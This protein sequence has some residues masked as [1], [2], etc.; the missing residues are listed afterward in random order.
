[1]KSRSGVESLLLPPSAAPSLPE[2][3]GHPYEWGMDD[4]HWTTELRA[5]G[6]SEGAPYIQTLPSKRDGRWAEGLHT[7]RLGA[8]VQAR[9]GLDV[10]DT[11]YYCA[12]AVDAILLW[13]R[14][15]GA[16]GTSNRSRVRTQV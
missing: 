11:L 2:P 1:L 10:A 14:W 13:F 8:W 4:E 6:A 3:V 16:V 12:G 9:G 7:S 15:G 5:S